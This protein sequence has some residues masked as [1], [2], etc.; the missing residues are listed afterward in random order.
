MSSLLFKLRHRRETIVYADDAFTT[1]K[2]QACTG[3]D[4]RDSVL[5]RND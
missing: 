3:G 1:S 4:E 5:F 2:L